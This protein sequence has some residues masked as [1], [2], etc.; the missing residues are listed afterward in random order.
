MRKHVTKEEIRKNN[1]SDQTSPLL[2]AHFLSVSQQN[3]RSA[4]R[5]PRV[6]LLIDQ[7]VA[8]NYVRHTREGMTNEKKPVGKLNYI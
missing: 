7:D 6:T 1:N 8:S 3:R 4:R 2:R 5:P